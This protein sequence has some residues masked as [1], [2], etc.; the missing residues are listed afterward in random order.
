[1]NGNNLKLVNKLED[2]LYLNK[3]DKYVYRFRED[4][5]DENSKKDFIKEIIFL[6]S[7]WFS[8]EFSD[9][10]DAK[11]NINPNEVNEDFIRAQFNKSDLYFP[12][13]VIENA[14]AFFSKR[15]HLYAES[16]RNSIPNNSPL[17]YC[18]F[19]T[20]Y[21]NRLLWDNYTKYKGIAFKFDMLEDKRFFT[22]SVKMIYTYDQ[23]FIL[24]SELIIPF[25]HVSH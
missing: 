23:P 14:V 15:P 3:L 1:V 8:N 16:A 22:T 17:V 21:N 6:N 4:K 24:I 18:C 25:C 5:I 20:D 13:N 11:F 9:P 12:D 19:T 7:L 2:F 10:T